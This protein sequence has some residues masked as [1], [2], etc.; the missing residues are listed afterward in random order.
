[1][2]LMISASGKES[3]VGERA[4]RSFFVGVCGKVAFEQ[5]HE[6]CEEPAVQVSGEGETAVQRS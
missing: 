3:R 1:M 5:R 2:R 6:S 4:G